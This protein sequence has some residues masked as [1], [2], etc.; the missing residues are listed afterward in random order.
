MGNLAVLPLPEV[1]NLALEL[2]IFPL[3]FVM[4]WQGRQSFVGALFV[5][6][7]VAYNMIVRTGGNVANPVTIYAGQNRD[8]ANFILNT[9][10]CSMAIVFSIVATFWSLFLDRVDLLPI[11]KRI[12]AA[13]YRSKNRQ[14]SYVHFFVTILAMLCSCVGQI[15][16]TYYMNKPGNELLAWLLG[17]LIPVPVF[18]AYGF[19]AY[20]FGDPMIF[21]GDEDFIAENGVRNEKAIDLLR[22]RRDNIL[23]A[24]VPMA[25]FQFLGTL[26]MGGVRF[27]WDDV[28]VQWPVAIGV[29][30]VLIFVLL[31]IAIVM[32]MRRKR[33]SKS[34]ATTCDDTGDY[35]QQRPV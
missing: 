34:T 11:G 22:T 14:V 20:F 8:E 32:Y 4:W 5:L 23:K 15:L 6:P 18:V 33:K 27:T 19:Y 24:V 7:I 10:L 25:L 30:G 9:V 13:W 26:V 1:S 35:Y 29:L 16:Y 2:T 17:L 28:D 21:G 12:I 31:L 3:F